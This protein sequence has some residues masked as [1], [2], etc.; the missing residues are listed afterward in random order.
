MIWLRLDTENL[1]EITSDDFLEKTKII[2]KKLGEPSFI[3]P[4][5]E[6]FLTHLTAERLSSANVNQAWLHANPKIWD[7]LVNYY[8]NYQYTFY[9]TADSEASLYLHGFWT[10][11]EEKICRTFHAASPLEKARL[12]QTIKNPRLQTLALRILARNFPENLL[13]EQRVAFTDHMKKIR[14]DDGIIDY[15]GKKR[16]TPEAAVLEMK[17]LADNGTLSMEQ[18]GLLTALE[19][20]VNSLWRCP[21]GAMGG[22]RES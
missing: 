2:S 16:L 21:E 20:Y 3:L 12:T 4:M 15:Q 10:P 9:P 11:E 6:R 22:L 7:A 17:T 13:A 8:T 5:K 14:E 18:R 1:M 19:D